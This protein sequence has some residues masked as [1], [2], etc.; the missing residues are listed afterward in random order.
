MFFAPPQA[1]GPKEIN[2]AAAAAE[3]KGSASGVP[4]PKYGDNI[5]VYHYSVLINIPY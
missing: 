4:T 1:E 3:A 2:G 5:V